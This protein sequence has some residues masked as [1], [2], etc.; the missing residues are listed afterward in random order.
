MSDQHKNQVRQFLLLVE[1]PADPAAQA[2]AQQLASR[3]E[4]ARIDSRL[5][6]ETMV[7]QARLG[8]AFEAKAG[9]QTPANPDSILD[10]A[11]LILALADCRDQLLRKLG[12]DATAKLSRTTAGASQAIAQACTALSRHDLGREVSECA[13]DLGSYAGVLEPARP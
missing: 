2:L 9:G 7:L 5:L 1:G 8:E 4:S 13:K 12:S 11:G 10:G 6:L 3:V